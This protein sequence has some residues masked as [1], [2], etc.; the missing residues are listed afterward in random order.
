MNKSITILLES[1]GVDTKLKLVGY[2][3]QML[4][5]DWTNAKWG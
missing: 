3:T 5:G 1:N 2:P 4:D